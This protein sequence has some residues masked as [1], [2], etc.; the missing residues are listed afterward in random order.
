M[1]GQS[2]NGV[3]HAAP[4]RAAGQMD[5]GVHDAQKPL[6]ETALAIIGAIGLDGPINQKRPAH[7]GIAIHKSPIT[8]I[9]A[10]V[11]VIAHA[12]VLAWRD[13]HLVTTDLLLNFASPFRNDRA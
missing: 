4:A 5:E 3:E 2:M 8:A 13:H 12:K 1:K 9:E 7:N 10:V 11:A 6:P